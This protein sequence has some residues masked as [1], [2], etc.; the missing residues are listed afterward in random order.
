MVSLGYVLSHLTLALRPK[1][2]QI[3]QRRTQRDQDIKSIISS[4]FGIGRS[5]NVRHFS[6]DLMRVVIMIP[7]II[8]RLAEAK[9]KNSVNF[10]LVI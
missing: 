6:P 10:Y 3:E 9:L 7:A 2:K 8:P 5:Q 4:D 1:Q